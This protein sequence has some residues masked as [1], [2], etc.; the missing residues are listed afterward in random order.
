MESADPA[1][2]TLSLPRRS[3][4]K[5]AVAAVVSLLVVAGLVRVVLTVWEPEPDDVVREFLSAL[6]HRQ[7][8]KALSLVKATDR[9]TGEEARFLT[10]SAIRDG[11][12]T[13]KVVMDHLPA[14]GDTSADVEVWL[15]NGHRAED[16]TFRLSKVD[17]GW[18]LEDPFITFQF[19]PMPLWYL[20]VNGVKL[21][22][23][24]NDLSAVPQ[25]YV[26]FPGVYRFYQDTSDLVEI[27]SEP[28]TLL[29]GSSRTIDQ[30]EV[31][32]TAKAVSPVQQAV[33][34]HIDECAKRT[35][36]ENTGCP[37]GIDLYDDEIPV[38]DDS[39]R[40]YVREIANVRWKVLRYPTI[41]L[42]AT[43]DAFT[44]TASQPGIVQLAGTGVNDDRRRIPFTAQ[45][46]VTS[47]SLVAG[48][49]ADGVMSVVPPAKRYGDSVPPT[50]GERCQRF[51]D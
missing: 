17:E 30:P 43:G 11:W 26:F 33:N 34:A 5:W 14:W 42:A 39:V 8:D 45:C 12:R 37:F 15:A 48:L 6:Q 41:A 3:R 40:E 51:P 47:F 23:E 10:G 2:P 20:D 29:P 31:T 50:P 44:I 35:T 1:E 7:V 4:V 18:R 24:L 22:K 36:T 27:T 25:Q 19:W 28:V 21:P 16:G 38:G 46:Y 32:A 49:T 9:P 13:A